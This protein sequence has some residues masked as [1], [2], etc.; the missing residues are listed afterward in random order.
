MTTTGADV[1]ADLSDEDA[2]ALWLS[3]RAGYFPSAREKQIPPAGDWFVWMLL[4]GRGFGKTQTGS[5][6]LVERALTQ[7]GDYAIVAPTFAAARDVCVENSTSGVLAVL[8]RRSVGVRTWNRSIGELHLTNGSKMRLASAEEPDRLRGWNFAGGWCDELAAWRYDATWYEAL[9]PAVRLG[10]R[11]QIVVTTTPRPTALVR[12]LADRRDGS[13]VVTRG[14][15]WENSYNLS[16]HALDE[17]K[18]R[19]AGTRLGRQ[20][21]EGQLLDDVEGALWRREWIDNARTGLTVADVRRKLARIAIAI[22]PG[23]VDDETG[24][25][26]AGRSEEKHCPV[27]GPVDAPH[28]FVLADRT[29]G[30][31]A[32]AWARVAIDLYDELEADKVVAEVNG[33][34]DMVR[35]TLRTVRSGLPYDEVRATRGKQLRADPISALYEQ[36]R[37]HHVGSFPDLEDQLCTWVPGEPG[38]KSPDRLDACVWA[39]TYLDIGQRHVTKTS[40]RVTARRQLAPSRPVGRVFV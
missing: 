17:L 24:I 10:E 29:C 14:S 32:D 33:A 8:R 5:E 26:A 25:V 21:L 4:A 19:Y 38:Q 34:Y 40:A 6:W 35:F 27:C 2:V 20:E 23:H 30:N 37:V 36:G 1:V 16:K 12:D 31:T 13:V 7:V 39:L 28:G 18:A 15:T 11:P 9:V 3:L 22:D